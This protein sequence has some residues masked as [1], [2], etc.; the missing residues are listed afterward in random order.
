MQVDLIITELNVGGA[1]RNFVNLA[2][3]LADAGDDVRVFSLGPLP[4]GEQAQL[5]KRLQHRGIDIVSGQATGWRSLPHC[6]GRLRRWMRGPTREICQTFLFH[7]N[8]LGGLGANSRQYR[9]MIGGLRVAEDTAWRCRLESLAVR[10]MDRLVCVSDA[11]RRFAQRRLGCRSD[12]A[13]VIPNGV[14]V[15]T[16]RQSGPFDW[17]R[18]GWPSDAV[19]SLFVGRLHPQKG[20]VDLQRQVNRLAPKDDP[21]R[22]LLIVGDGP[23]RESLQ[24]WAREQ[25]DQR[26]QCLGWR[27]D[28]AALT[29]AC[30][31]LILPSRY[32]GMPNVVMEAMAAG[33]PVVVSGVEGIEELVPSNAP[34][35][36]FRVGDSEA[37]AGLAE[38]FLADPEFAAKVGATNQ[39]HMRSNFSIQTM[40]DRYRALYQSLL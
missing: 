3:G 38:R 27:D 13:T 20:I 11:V 16:I 24:S 25:G 1:E 19:V 36:V 18:V 4:H 8:L 15:D 32:E 14:D 33:R 39:Q 21:K 9:R 6:Y 37:M 40:V 7:A 2:I 23:Q 29:N 22:R 17:S 30:R 28:V 31:V 26:V 10:R 5:L 34:E 12:Q 35:Q